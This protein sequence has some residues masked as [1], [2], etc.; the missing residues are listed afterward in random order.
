MLE[1][2]PKGAEFLRVEQSRDNSYERGAMNFL[3]R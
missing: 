2:T 3:V 1:A